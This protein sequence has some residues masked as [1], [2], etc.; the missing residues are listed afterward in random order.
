MSQDGAD[1]TVL[2]SVHHSQRAQPLFS[3]L[4]IKGQ[5]LEIPAATLTALTISKKGSSF[6]GS[7]IK[8]Q[9]FLHGRG[10]LLWYII[11]SLADIQSHSC[12]IL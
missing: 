11:P 3:I 2:H 9:A 8:M 1:C 7:G 5:N 4:W 12:P 10:V 6:T